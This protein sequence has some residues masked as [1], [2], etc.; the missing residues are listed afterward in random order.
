M[1]KKKI[2][3]GIIAFVI[4]LLIICTGNVFAEDEG[5]ESSYD[6]I[7]T[8]DGLT[9]DPP[10]TVILNGQEYKIFCM[11]YDATLF[12]SDTIEPYTQGQ[13]VDGGCD[14]DSVDPPWTGIRETI[15][16]KKVGSLPIEENQK[17]AYAIAALPSIGGTDQGTRMCEIQRAIWRSDTNIVEG[18][19]ELSQAYTEQ[20]N[21]IQQ[22]IANAENEQQ[23]QEAE[24]RLQVLNQNISEYRQ[25][26]VD[27]VY[28]LLD[29]RGKPHDALEAEAQDF[30]DY[31]N[32]LQAAGGFNPTD[33]TNIQNVK[34]GV[35]QNTQVYTVGPFKIDY[36]HGWSHVQGRERIDFSE[37]TEVQVLD[38]N[39]AKQELV[40]IVKSDG[41]SILNDANAE[42]KYPEPGQEFYVKFKATEGAQKVKLNV[43]F[44]Y[45][46]KID[47]T[48]DEY[49]GNVYEWEWD[50]QE[51]G[52]HTHGS[53]T[54]GP[55]G[56]LQPPPS[57]TSYKYVLSKTKTSD[58]QI[59]VGTPTV[60]LFAFDALKVDNETELIVGGDEGID[61]TM[62]LA[63]YVWVDAKSNKDNLPDGRDGTDPNER[64]RSNF[65]HK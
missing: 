21:Q 50:K 19:E 16:Y 43:K 32:E 14:R 37:I 62:E 23:R 31:Y 12:E 59:M 20:L 48:L 36:I 1:S 56:E 13:E 2:L 33:L 49:H 47:G 60:N 46:E 45:I 57:C 15:E 35:D 18:M 24:N 63:G 39:G 9:E 27:R 53:S 40:D 34:V 5:S 54:P 22:E 29:E 38:Q 41:S 4:L 10:M 25:N 51:T 7:W 65:I 30:Q 8:S 11:E 6:F 58:A 42:Y 44:Y 3:L 26:L 52:T 55:N 17:V 61:I 64:C 28:E